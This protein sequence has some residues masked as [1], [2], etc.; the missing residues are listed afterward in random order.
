MDNG[1]T[2]S[3]PSHVLIFPNLKLC[4]ENWTLVNY[5]FFEFD[6]S[7]GLNNPA[8]PLFEWKFQATFNGIWELG[9]CLKYR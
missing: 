7:A 1:R 6:K 5:N 2:T 9:F 4:R 3:P 8:K